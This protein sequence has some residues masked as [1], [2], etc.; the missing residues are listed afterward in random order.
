MSRQQCDQPS[1]KRHSVPLMIDA[2]ASVGE[3]IPQRL[4]HPRFDLRQR[5]PVAAQPRAQ[6]RVTRIVALKQGT[7]KLLPK[8]TQTS[9]LVVVAQSLP[10]SPVPLVGTDPDDAIGA[11]TT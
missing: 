4:V 3:V 6:T 9:G 1:F 11:T 5:R 8:H 10:Q 7:T 2:Q